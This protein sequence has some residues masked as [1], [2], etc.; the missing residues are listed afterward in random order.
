MNELINALSALNNVVAVGLGGSRGLGLADEKSDYDFVLFRNGGPPIP[1]PLIMAALQS[2]TDSASLPANQAASATTNSGKA[3]EVFQKDL[4]LVARE[5]SMA[6]SGK[7]HWNIKPLF[8]HGD[9]STGLI[10]H[11]VYLEICAEKDS[12]MTNLR[13]Q[14]LPLPE[15]L[16]RSLTEFFLTQATITLIHAQ[17]IRK[18]A[19]SQYL[20]A[21]C[22]GFVFYINIV[23]FSI[24]RK[25]PILERGGAKLISSLPLAPKDYNNKVL[26]SFQA[27][28]N[29]DFEKATTLLSDMLN[30]IKTLAKGVIEGIGPGQPIAVTQAPAQPL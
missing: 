14:A 20:I 21:L 26:L 10:S 18:S 29:G 12:C 2:Y 7:F 9:L 17:K 5:I 11:I 1:T 23:I 8:P 25:Y 28:S 24:N 6:R 4:S 19:D 15:L 16:T 13:N 3:I 22:S 30:E 27:A